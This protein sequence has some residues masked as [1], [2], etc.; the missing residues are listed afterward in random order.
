M[1]IHGQSELTEEI[2]NIHNFYESLVINEVH[3]IMLG[4]LHESNVIADIICLTLNQLPPRYIRHK[5]DMLYYLTNKERSEMERKV[6]K[7]I[8]KSIAIVIKE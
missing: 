1:K 3:K 7:A 2:S 6:K 5:V 4:K 8:E